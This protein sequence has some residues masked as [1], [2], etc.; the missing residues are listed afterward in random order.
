MPVVSCVLL[1]QGSQTLQFA[2][3]V[4]LLG[5]GC[6]PLQL[7]YITVSTTHPDP[8]HM[9]NNKDNRSITHKAQL[10]LSWQ[11][12]KTHVTWNHTLCVLFHF[13]LY[14]EVP[15]SVISYFSFPFHTTYIYLPIQLCTYLTIILARAKSAGLKSA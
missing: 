9:D 13:T 6:N 12:S 3:V 5:I 14:G 1:L 11:D 2:T 4:L 15:V 8:E 7:D 10:F